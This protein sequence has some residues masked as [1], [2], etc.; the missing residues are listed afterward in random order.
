VKTG[1]AVGF[2]AHYSK[3]NQAGKEAIDRVSGS[4]VFAR[5]PIA[6]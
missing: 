5:D 1:A 4:G 6:C 3:G 2:G